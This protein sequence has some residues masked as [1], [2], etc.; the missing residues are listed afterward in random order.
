[1]TDFEKSYELKIRTSQAKAAARR[2]QGSLDKVEKSIVEVGKKFDKHIGGQA[3]QAAKK[4]NKNIKKT[5]FNL[6]DLRGG[7]DKVARKLAIVSAAFVGL[8]GLG[9]RNA[10]KLNKEMANVSTLLSG[11]VEQAE[12]LKRGIQEMAKE[13]GKDTSDLA[14]GLYQVVSALGESRENMDQLTISAKAGVAGL[15]TTK[16]SIDLLSAVT[17]GYGDTSKEAMQKASDLSFMTVKL[18]QTTFPELSQAMGRVIPLAAALNT[19][20]EELFGTMATLTG[21][22]GNTAEVSTQLASVYAAFLKPTEK[23]TEA[24]QKFGFETASAMMKSVGLRQALIN[25]NKSAGFTEETLGKQMAKAAQ[26]AGYASFKAMVD[27]EGLTTAWDKLTDSTGIADS[28]LAK[29]LSRKEALVATMALLGGQSDVYIQ[30]LNEME[31]AS[32]A[33]DEAFRKQTEGINKQGHGWEKTK[34]R[35]LV[36]SQRAGDKLLPVLD[37]LLDKLEPVLKYIE[38]MSDETLESWMQ[39]GKWVAILAVATKGL[40][41]FLGVIEGI[42]A[43]KNLTMGLQAA[44]TGMATMTTKANAAKGAML[45]FKVAGVASAL[46]VGTAIGTML[47]DIFFAPHAKARAKKEETLEE[48]SFQARQ[49]AR[50]GTLEQKEEALSKLQVQ[51]KTVEE[52]WMPSV[53]DI[54][55]TIAAPFTGAKA[56]GVL[57]GE[58]L[59]EAQF[60]MARLQRQVEAGRERQL[61]EEYGIAPNVSREGQVNYTA[62]TNMTINAPGGDVSS[63]ERAVKKVVKQENRKQEQK[64]RR[65]AMGVTAGEF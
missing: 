22:T 34:Q 2:L 50:R 13:T 53:E 59:G 9:V 15:A 20:Q 44:T 49:V 17:K 21:V 1:M 8:G 23:M 10:M 58:R 4:L 65:A 30:K 62:N 51:Y 38:N 48:A 33:T 55:G 40:S 42:G 5:K 54:A 19:R 12:A 61:Q 25:L 24:A 43:L 47:N 36:F 6:K 18:G 35:L 3:V 29:M 56:P 32:G 63:I 52:E 28:A 60:E 31:K 37:R 26:K 41:G 46:A 14:G 45:G 27:A 16:E 39:F 7:L 11:G 64:I 57:R